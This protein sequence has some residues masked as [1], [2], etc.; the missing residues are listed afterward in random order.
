MNARLPKQTEDEIQELVNSGDFADS[1]DVVV[2]GVHLLT[3]Q[4]K[5]LEHLRG[6][7]QEGLDAAERGEGFEFTPH[8]MGKIREESRT[9]A[10]SG[11]P[12]NPDVC[13]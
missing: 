9:L 3:E 8:L 13:G 5:H 1:T 12:L 2:R 11:E 7:L 4:R 10:Y 6:L